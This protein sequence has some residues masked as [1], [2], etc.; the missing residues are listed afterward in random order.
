MKSIAVGMAYKWADEQRGKGFS[1]EFHAF[2]VPGYSG[3]LQNAIMFNLHMGVLDEHGK[4]SREAMLD[5]FDKRF[6]SRDTLEIFVL[7]T[8]QDTTAMRLYQHILNTKLGTEDTNMK[9]FQILVNGSNPPL[10]TGI[11]APGCWLLNHILERIYITA[12]RRWGGLLDDRLDEVY[13]PQ[14]PNDC[15][16]KTGKAQLNG[17]R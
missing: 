3:T 7:R 9:T 10:M 1:P 5:W 12:A 8:L 15:K 2:F 14:H 4:K 6:E 16:V 11:R 17:W 13:R